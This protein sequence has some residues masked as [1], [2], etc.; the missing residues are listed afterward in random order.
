[1]HTYT[2]CRYINICLCMYYDALFS[3]YV[4]VCI[5]HNVH[6][7]IRFSTS[8]CTH[9]VSSSAIH[10]RLTYLHQGANENHEGRRVLPLGKE[11]TKIAVIGWGAN[12][13]YAPLANYPG[14]GFSAWG[15]RIPDC[16][17]VTPLQGIR[18]RFENDHVSVVYARGS[19]VEKPDTSGYEEALAIAHGA[20]AIIYVGGNRNCEGGPGKG[21]RHCESEGYDRPDIDLPV[22]QTNLIKKLYEINRNIVFAVITGSP[23]SFNWEAEH[24]P[25]ILVMWYAGQQG[26]RALAA[27]LSGDA[28]PSGKTPVTWPT[29]LQQLPDKFDMS[30]STPPGRGYRYLTEL[31]LYFFGYGLTY[32]ETTFHIVVLN[33]KKPIMLRIGRHEAENKTISLC[34]LVR[35]KGPLKTEEVV[36]VYAEPNAAVRARAESAPAFLLVGFARTPHSIAPNSELRICID[37]HVRSFRL[38]A[39]PSNKKSTRQQ[40]VGV[41]RAEDFLVLP[42][43]YYIHVGGASPHKRQGLFVDKGAVSP[44]ARAAVEIT[45]SM[46]LEETT[47]LE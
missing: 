31:P 41:N 33:D 19:D 11:V 21:G 47:I 6:M 3:R 17:I 38:M 29:G 46:V 39:N 15:P 40:H 1:M 35:N 28:S 16:H 10:R 14:C 7:S 24:L 42:G 30:P 13:T 26:G 45:D 32:G 12:D 9:R 22:V 43:T 2:L 8:R 23:I 18:E 4:C 25:A 34:V 37:I 44:Q 5:C 27:V 20:D 36:Q